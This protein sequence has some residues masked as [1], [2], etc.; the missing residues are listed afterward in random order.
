MEAASEP[1]PTFLEAVVKQL[2]LK[3]EP[4]KAAIDVVCVDSFNKVPT[5][6]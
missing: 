3:L 1:A 5:E 6:N 2:G 4:A